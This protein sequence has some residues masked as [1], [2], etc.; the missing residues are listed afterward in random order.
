[1]KAVL[2]EDEAEECRLF[3]VEPL[4]GY[5]DQRSETGE[6]RIWILNRHRAEFMR[7]LQRDAKRLL[8][9]KHKVDVRQVQ[10]QSPEA[11]LDDLQLAGDL[12]DCDVVFVDRTVGHALFAQPDAAEASWASDL[13][14]D[15]VRLHTSAPVIR[16]SQFTRA[17]PVSGKEFNNHVWRPFD[18]QARLLAKDDNVEAYRASFDLMLNA[19]LPAALGGPKSKKVD[20]VGATI[21]EYCSGLLKDN[22]DAKAR[23]DDLNE[24][25][26]RA[27]RAL[28]EPGKRG[29][30][31]IMYATHEATMGVGEHRRRS[32]YWSDKQHR[33]AVRRRIL[34][35]LQKLWFSYGPGK[36]G[37]SDRSGAY[38]QWLDL[39]T[40][41]YRDL[42]AEKRA[43]KL[44]EQGM[45]LKGLSS[46]IKTWHE[47]AQLDGEPGKSP[48]SRRKVCVIDLTTIDGAKFFRVEPNA[49]VNEAYVIWTETNMGPLYSDGDL[50]YI[51]GEI[52]FQEFS[53]RGPDPE[54]TFRL[55][56]SDA[57]DNFPASDSRA[58]WDEWY[59]R[60]P[61]A[62]VVA[63]RQGHL[64][65]TNDLANTL[66]LGM[67]RFYDFHREPSG[68]ELTWWK[69]AEQNF[70]HLT[71]ELFDV[72]EQSRKRS[73]CVAGKLSRMVTHSD[74]DPSQGPAAVPAIG[75]PVGESPTV[76]DVRPP[77]PRRKLI[78]AKKTSK[79]RLGGRAKSVRRIVTGRT[80]S[81]RR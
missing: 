49:Q 79:T 28:L 52:F 54:Y 22:A 15:L 80:L 30:A 75:V 29:P 56:W 36:D 65:A 64:Q 34:F 16:V 10:P 69:D 61:R 66:G 31:S 59:K 68:S 63:Q 58:V 26:T 39:M 43:I 70:A 11:F 53:F 67:E 32:L 20:L 24:S 17:P 57:S 6:V 27:M 71:E 74:Q 5:L 23:L 1:M 48:A 41:G 72:E 47:V 12:A 21:D 14:A 33:L 44:L 3:Y 19:C 13:V 51:D 46:K 76:P 35:G 7:D 78:P 8:G 4:A 55:E 2:I 9:S 81:K 42:P 77:A 40:V 60:H 73:T 50:R 38:G 62:Q 18:P 45:R 37:D 25:A